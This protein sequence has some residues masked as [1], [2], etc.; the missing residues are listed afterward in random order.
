M[1]APLITTARS[2]ICSIFQP[3]FVA[4]LNLELSSSGA[5]DPLGTS[6]SVATRIGDELLHFATSI[7]T[8]A[9]HALAITL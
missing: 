1:H 2:R 7:T 9:L 6:F 8:T 4:Q 3:V 5:R